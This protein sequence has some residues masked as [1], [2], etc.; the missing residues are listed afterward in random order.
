VPPDK[1]VIDRML[2]KIN[3]KL[4]LGEYNQKNKLK[5]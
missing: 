2:S 1:R 3:K 4:R 5:K